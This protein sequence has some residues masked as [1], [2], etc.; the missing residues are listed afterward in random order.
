MLVKAS[1]A[2]EEFKISEVLE[3]GNL[4]TKIHQLRLTTEA[5]ERTNAAD[6]ETVLL[7]AHY[8]KLSIAQERQ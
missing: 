4:G 1:T 6:P 5:L 7:R 8:D 2:P 3:S